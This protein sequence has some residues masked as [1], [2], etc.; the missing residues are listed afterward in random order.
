MAAI[1]PENIPPEAKNLPQW[2]CYKLEVVDSDKTKV[3]YSPATGQRASSTDA[4]TWTSFNAAQVA[5]QDLEIYDGIC[6]FVTEEA[7]IVFID[8]DKCIQDGIIAAWAAEI[9]K[10]FDSY[11]EKSQSGKGLHILT[12]GKKPG[13]RCR[14][15][16]YPHGVEI[17]DHARQ[18]CLTGDIIEGHAIIEARQEALDGLYKEMFGDEQQ[19]STHVPPVHRAELQDDAL[20]EKA[21]H[22]KNG[23]EFEALW[24]GSIFGYYGDDSAADMALTNMLAFWTAGDALQMDRLFR[25]SKLMRPKWDENRGAETYGQRTIEKAISDARE[26]Y[27]PEAD[28]PKEL[29]ETTPEEREALLDAIMEE[30]GSLISEEEANKYVIPSN[31]KLALTLERDNF[32]SQFMAYGSE[33]SDAFP[34]YWFMG[35]LELLAIINDQK[36]YVNIRTERVYPNVYLNLLGSSTTSH[37]STILKKVA[38]ILDRISNGQYNEAPE[39]GSPEGWLE[40]M[41]ETPRAYCNQD[42]SSG[43]INRMKKQ[44]YMSGMTEMLNNCYDG[45]SFTKRNTKKRK[46]EPNKWRIEHPY[47]NQLYA[48]TPSKF[49]FATSAIDVHSG[50]WVR[51]LHAYPNYDREQFTPLGE[52]SDEL[53]VLDDAIVARLLQ[54]QAQMLAPTITRAPIEPDGWDFY[55][56]WQVNWNK[57]IRKTN[58]DFLGQIVGRYTIYAIKLGILFTMGRSDFDRAKMVISTAHIKEACALVDNYFVPH[59]LAVRDLIGE[60]SAKDANLI[61]KIETVLRV[62]GG[63]LPHRALLR[64]I[65]AVQK[66]LDEALSTMV[67]SG[68]VT[69]KKVKNPHGRPTETIFLNGEDNAILS[70]QD[71]QYEKHDAEIESKKVRSDNMGESTI[72][73]TTTSNHIV[74]TVS[75]YCHIVTD[76]NVKDNPGVCVGE[77][78]EKLVT[79]S[80]MENNHDAQPQ[81]CPENGGDNKGDI[82]V[83]ICPNRHQEGSETAKSGFSDNMKTPDDPGGESLKCGIGPHPRKENLELAKFKANV[84]TR[85]KN[86]CLMCGQHFEVPLS[87]AYQGGYICE[88]CRRDGAPAEPPKADAQT[89]LGEVKA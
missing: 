63:R 65:R 17:Y 16:K 50:F 83:T 29:W 64:K 10:R 30:R 66:Q 72:H 5:Y 74:D 19:K 68:A 9:V 44:D 2:D 60:G 61:I 11:T 42:E 32:I 73:K 79:I 36:T 39:N 20:L 35:A 27:K 59:A 4:Q 22:A 85:R 87:I 13:K 89:R 81:K 78:T 33:L 49:S 71:G 25:Q 26:F 12:K 40:A 69:I 51:F 37:K 56:Q 34:D 28:Y 84:Q 41:S 18:C 43:F 57:K 62:N 77:S 45:T 55:K 52:A 48:T 80:I 8:L 53:A 31:P 47:Y 70:P 14:T 67:V 54:I 21:M 1:Y 58:D 6:F 24:N 3:P 82:M 88:P 76:E 46:G 15:A 23:R 75:P 38:T 7:G 86:T